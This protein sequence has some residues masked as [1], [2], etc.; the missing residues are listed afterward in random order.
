MKRRH[1]FKIF[2]AIMLSGLILLG[3]YLNATGSVNKAAD[4]DDTSNIIFEIESGQSASEIGSALKEVGLIRSSY[5]FVHYLSQND[6]AGDLKAGRFSLSPSMTG[7]EIIELLTN[8][9]TGDIV[10]TIIEG[11]TI[12]DIDAALTNEGLITAGAFITCTETCDFSMYTFLPETSLEGYLFPD[13]F[14]LDADTFETY[15]FTTRLLDNFEA[16]TANIDTGDRTLEDVMIVASIIEKEVRTA[17]DRA[18]VSDIIWRRL[19]ADWTLGMCSTINYITGETEITYED[20]QIDSP[21]NTRIYSGL[22]P[23]AIANPGLASIEAAANPQAN[24]YW[25]FL[26]AIDTGETIYAISNEEHEANKAQ[27]LD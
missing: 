19:D 12:S 6:L 13:T 24:D 23:T 16:K 26:N 27:Y 2:P 25:F 4:I 20:I 17:E 10:F 14:F 15:D 7:T 1:K 18:L 22:P 9:A 8:Q 5:G 21:Y 3:L 11:W